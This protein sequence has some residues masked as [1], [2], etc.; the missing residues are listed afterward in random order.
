MS[1]KRPKPL[2]PRIIDRIQ[3]AMS[4]GR[5]LDGLWIGSWRCRPEDLTRLE[6]ALLLV[7]EHSPLDYARINREL[8]RVWVHVLSYPLGEYNSSLKACMLDERYVADPNTRTEQIAST[9]VHEATHARLDRYGIAY[10]EGRRAR[11]EAICF[12]R[13]SAFAARL[14]D[15]AQLL[16]EITRYLDWYAE[17]PEQFHDG[18]LETNRAI[19]EVEAMRHVGMPEWAIRTVLTI[20]PVLVRVR[21]LLRLARR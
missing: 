17:N 21:G 1:N 10:E 3:L 14:P 19:G 2:R 5:Q 13:E 15:G 8:R 7:K 20:R 16:E 4:E 11:I 12:R 18:H 9:I 6:A